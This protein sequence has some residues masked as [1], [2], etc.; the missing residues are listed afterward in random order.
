MVEGSTE[1]MVD[2]TT[3]IALSQGID[4]NQIRKS[5]RRASSKNAKTCYFCGGTTRHHKNDLSAPLQARNV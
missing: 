1:A 3:D 4:K 2:I 5:R